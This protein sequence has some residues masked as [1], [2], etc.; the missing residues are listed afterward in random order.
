M[1][2]WTLFLL[3]VIFILALD[4]GV[5]N[6]TP[7]IISTKEASK[8]TLI[9]VT[10]SFLFSGVIY[11][12][13]TTD[14]IA[15]PDDLKPAVASMKF[16]TGYLIELSLSVDNIFVIA[17]IFASFKIPQ[18]YQHRVLFWG[19]LGAIVFRGLMIFFGVMLINKFTWTTYLFGAFLLFTAIK[20]LFSGEDE[21][22]QPKD[23]FVYKIL[24][25]IIPITAETDGEKF[26]ITT[27][28]AKKA[29]TP[30][31]VALIVIEVMDV[32][33]AVDSVPA[34]LAITSDPFLVFSSNIFA[35]LGLRSMYFFLANMLAKFSYLEYSLVAI[36]AFVGLKMLLHDYIH[37]PEWASLG[38]IALSLL[39]GIL[40]SL[41]FGEEKVLNDLDEE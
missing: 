24:G 25:K 30:L 6:K 2:V 35:I 11:W 5:F 7:H 17:I 12:L 26:F 39:V 36:L 21:D 4:L 10:L 33:F 38:F 19:I 41:K 18:K 3:A 22:F 29:A 13:Y 27:K 14:Y 34:I 31:F 23:S 32:L 1:I 37:L 40:V 15:N 20:M 16:I 8:W 9:W 28:K